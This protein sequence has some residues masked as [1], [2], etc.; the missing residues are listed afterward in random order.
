[1]KNK[2]LKNIEWWILIFAILLCIV[3]FVALYST[4]QSSNF[5]DL[6]MGVKEMV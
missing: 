1:M 4:T 6:K 3:G 5:G 2:I